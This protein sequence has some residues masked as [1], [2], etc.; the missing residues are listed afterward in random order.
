MKRLAVVLTLFVSGTAQAAVAWA[1][2]DALTSGFGVHA[3]VA[4]LPVPFVGTLGI[5]ASGERAWTAQGTGRVAAGVT[6]RDLNLPLTRVDAFATLGGEYRTAS[7]AQASALAAYAEAGLRGP[8]FGPA[9]W[10]AFARANTAGQ[11]GAGVG[12]ELRF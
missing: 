10:R 3:G 9:G 7:A 5:E 8:L 11:F 1:G 12:L 6:L 2:A 4:V